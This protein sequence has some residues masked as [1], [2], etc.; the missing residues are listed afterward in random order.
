[1]PQEELA[2]SALPGLM[3]TNKR[4]RYTNESAK[5]CWSLLLKEVVSIS[6]KHQSKV[7]YLYLAILSTAVSAAVYSMFHILELTLMPLLISLLFV[8][9]YLQ[10]R[11]N[12]FTVA[13]VSTSHSIAVSG[14]SMS[15]ALSVIELIEHNR[16]GSDY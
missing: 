15:N 11:K 1:M 6:L 9:R 13:T 3:I 12:L 8:S 2:S 10:S 7:Y 14:T 16:G 5:T 4:I